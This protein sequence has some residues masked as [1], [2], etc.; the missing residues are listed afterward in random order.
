MTSSVPNIN[1]DLLSAQQPTKPSERWWR[2]FMDLYGTVTGLVTTVAGLAG[3]SGTWN[4]TL[5]GP[6]AS[7]QSITFKWEKQGTQVTLWTDQNLNATATVA[8]QT[9]QSTSNLP[10]AI[11]PSSARSMACAGLLDNGIG[12]LMGVLQVNN[13]SPGSIT[14]FLTQTFAGANP[15]VVTGFNTFT[16][17]G[18]TGINAAL[19][20]SYS[21]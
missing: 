6:W 15:V 21:L 2:W 4:T 18:P 19:S 20:V 17:A 9:M 1:E 5:S 7:A 12:G 16:G 11:T 14:L 8:G 13:G 3:Q 10:A